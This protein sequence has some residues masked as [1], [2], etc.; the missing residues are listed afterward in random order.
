MK[1]KEKFKLLKHFSI[2]RNSIANMAFNNLH[3]DGQCILYR[4]NDIK[5][6][7]TNTNVI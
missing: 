2:I 7:M 6:N 3:L 1:N 5:V 4:E